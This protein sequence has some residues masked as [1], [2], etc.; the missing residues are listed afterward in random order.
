MMTV[1]R[2]REI[3]DYNPETGWLTWR[4]FKGMLVMPGQRAGSVDAHGYRVVNPKFEGKVTCNKE[5]RVIWLWMTGEWPKGQ[6]DH[7]N[8]VRDDNRWA[9]LRV[10][11]NLQN[12]QNR[13]KVVTKTGLIGVSLRKSTGRYEAHIKVDG[14]KMHLGY[15]DTPE[16]ARTIHLKAKSLYHLKSG[17]A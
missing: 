4:K 5:H 3:F 13:T 10:V 9:N 16:Q 2:A 15:F 7:I 12:A 6:I 11:T 17:S 14:K 8:G 1:E